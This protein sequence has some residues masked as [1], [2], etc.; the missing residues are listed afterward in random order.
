MNQPTKHRWETLSSWPKTLAGVF[1]HPAAASAILGASLL[2]TFCA[3]LICNRMHSNRMQD[4]FDF[5][6]KNVVDALDERMLEYEQVLRGG[7]GLFAASDE[8]SRQDWANYVSN[9]EL[10]RYFPGIQAM[11]VSVAIPAE[12][13]S[14]L[15]ATIRDE[16][17]PD[18]AIHPVGNREFYTSITYIEPFDWRNQRAFGFDMY[19]DA[20]RREA[21][22]RA[23]RTGEPAMSGMV[24][25]VQETDSN[26]Q[27][28]WLFYLP[29]LDNSGP[30]NVGINRS[31]SARREDLK[32]FVYAAFRANDL[33]AGLLKNEIDDIK[34]EIYDSSELTPERL[35][36]DSDNTPHFEGGDHP[37]FTSNVSTNIRG[38]ELTLYFESCPGLFDSAG[39]NQSMLVACGG[40]TVDFLLFFVI[41]M[42]G[43]QKRRAVEIANSM[44]ETLQARDVLIS[45]I[46]A[47][48]SEAFLTIDEDGQVEMTNP[49]A[50]K[51]FAFPPDNEINL[52]DYM[53]RRS[54]KAITEQLASDDQEHRV[55]TIK[56]FRQNGDSFVCR[57]SLGVFVT[58][59]NNHFI[60][61]AHD[62]TDRI[63]SEQKIAEINQELIQA[64]RNAGKTEIANG[65]LHNVGNIINSINISTSQIKKQLEH[66]S[67]SKLDRICSL[68]AE[69]QSDFGSFVQHDARG[70]KLPAYLQKLRDTLIQEKSSVDIELNDLVRN[71]SHIKEVISSQQSEAKSGDAPRTYS[72]AEVLC[73]AI[74]ANKASLTG[75]DIEIVTEITSPLPKTQS[76]KHKILQVLVNLI[77]NACDSLIENQTTAPK[78]TVCIRQ[79]QTN[80]LYEVVDNGI[81]INRDT[82][83]KLFCHGFTTKETGHGFGLHSS[84]NAA[85]EL[86]G[87]LLATSKGIGSGATFT[88]SVPM[89]LSDG[90]PKQHANAT[91]QHPEGATV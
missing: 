26:T 35:L 46:F 12:D 53:S 52:K 61:V 70:Q 22:D 69:H 47:N 51:M 81:G 67:V 3:W 34:F 49:A 33:M 41:S 17:F 1:E 15:E 74:T 10:D 23:I 59:G 37:I 91:K 76:V 24:T 9:C 65:V 5:R 28:G 38:R 79:H 68:I 21:M 44:T 31:F 60:V 54:W 40:L 88:L 58:E 39:F 30:T 16:G 55:H 56:A 48:A 27:A 42:I 36:Y 6:V 7:V 43:R 13:K 73:D 71:V 62:D 78:I 72:P 29:I 75:N 85:N 20:T 2:L 4:R 32:Q 8:V 25:L 50:R 77:K 19:S 90:S 84:L 18:F 63:K 89:I 11:G 87:T 45:G 64:S 14:R 57:L 86:G 83:D 66:T 82:L 80:I